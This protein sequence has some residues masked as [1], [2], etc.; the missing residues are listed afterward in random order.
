M[1]SRRCPGVGDSSC[2]YILATWDTHNTCVSHRSCGKGNPCPRCISWGD[3][4]WNAKPLLV[5]KANTKRKKLWS[6]NK[7]LSSPQAPTLASPSLHALGDAFQGPLSLESR[8]GEG[9]G[10]TSVV[11]I[12]LQGDSEFPV[13]SEFSRTS[14]P[15]R[16]K[17]VQ[18]PSNDL[19]VGGN[20]LLVPTRVTYPE[21]S[22]ETQGNMSATQTSASTLSRSPGGEARS[23]TGLVSMREQAEPAAAGL[24]SFPTA[25]SRSLIP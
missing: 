13:T 24:V 8:V 2:P 5:K 22:R 17:L 16:G 7:S 12:P 15:A 4:E 3:K 20:S 9:S 14:S 10:A 19:V 6:S 11:S 18:N 21:C 23:S 1:A 25:E